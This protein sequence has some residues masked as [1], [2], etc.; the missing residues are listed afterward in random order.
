MDSI[1]VFPLAEALADGEADSLADSDAEGPAD[2]DADADSLADGEADSLA[3]GETTGSVTIGGS[4]TGGSTTGS[5]TT[6]GSTT[7]GSTTGGSTTGSVTI[8]CWL[9]CAEALGWPWPLLP[10]FARLDMTTEPVRPKASRSA[11]RT[12]KTLIRR[13]A[14]MSCSFLLDH[15]LGRLNKR[16]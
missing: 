1:F 16:G 7:G 10:P 4:T 12:E 8:G 5:V 11:V 13:N 14:D 6:G 3:D 15:R 9:G 2:S